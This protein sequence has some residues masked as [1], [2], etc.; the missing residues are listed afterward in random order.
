LVYAVYFDL[1][2][3]HIHAV[4]KNTRALLVAIQKVD[5]EVNTEKS[6]YM[7]VSYEQNA[8]Q[9]NSSIKIANIFF[10]KCVKIQIFWNSICHTPFMIYT[11]QLL[12]LFVLGMGE[13]E[14]LST[15][16]SNGANLPVPYDQ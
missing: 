13:T 16:A 3:K 12:F 7:F 1:L 6:K 4:K 9:S 11:V 2:G 14:S 8:R 10:E 15:A 5:L